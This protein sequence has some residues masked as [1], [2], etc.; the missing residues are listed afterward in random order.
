MKKDIKNI[1]KMFPIKIT[2]ISIINLPIARLNSLN[3]KKSLLLFDF[4]AFPKT[5]LLKER[6]I[7]EH[8]KL[9]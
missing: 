2:T 8:E 6:S 4:F 7:K 9:L 3:K 1:Q 5:I